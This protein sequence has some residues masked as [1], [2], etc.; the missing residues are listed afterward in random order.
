M[1][2]AGAA[3]GRDRQD[4]PQPDRGDV[5]GDGQAELAVHREPGGGAGGDQRLPC[6]ELVLLDD[7]AGVS[8]AAERVDELVVGGRV[9][10][11]GGNDDGQV[12][13]AQ[14]HGTRRRRFGPDDPG[15]DRQH[16]S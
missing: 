15:R 4:H 9:V 16:L 10:P 13:G 7:V 8:V 12:D 11:A 3:Q 2:D 14:P 6:E 5:A 1:V